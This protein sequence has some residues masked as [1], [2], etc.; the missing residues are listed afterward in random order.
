M[1][2]FRYIVFL[3]LLIVGG[4]SCKK[5]FLD[6]TPVDRFSDETVWSDP[7]L[8][9]TF[10]NNVYLGIQFPFS[11]VMISSS[12]DESMLVQDWETSNVTKSLIT[13]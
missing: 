9:Q 2:P 13:P 8:V 11:T 12:V 1:K 5:N 7:A 3:L 6:V 4:V 10:V